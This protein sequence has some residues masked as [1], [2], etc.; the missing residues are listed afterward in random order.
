MY[1]NIIQLFCLLYSEVVL[2]RED[3]DDSIAG[4]EFILPRYEPSKH[5]LYRKTIDGASVIRAYQTI[6]KEVSNLTVEEL[7]SE[8]IPKRIPYTTALSAPLPWD[9]QFIKDVYKTYGYEGSHG[10]DNNA[11]GGSLALT[12]HSV[13]NLMKWL[14]NVQGY[15]P[16]FHF[17]EFDNTFDLHILWV[18]FVLL[19]L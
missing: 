11:G 16:N 10:S 19:L 17:N 12:P 7:L 14:T 4:G 1:I 9:R 13:F 2:R 15:L 3:Y 5:E 8:A 18:L 6:F